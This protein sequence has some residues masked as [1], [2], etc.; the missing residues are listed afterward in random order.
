MNIM[1]YGFE[2]GPMLDVFFRLENEKIISI[3]R[4]LYDQNCSDKI[5][6][7]LSYAMPITNLWRG[8][9]ENCP[10]FPNEDISKYINKHMDWLM[11]EF[12]RDT[13]FF[14]E[15]YYEYTNIINYV[16]NRSY[17]DIIK[18]NIE[19]V[20]F[21]DI[22]HG[23]VRCMLYLLAK[24]MN[25]RT[26]F[27]FTVSAFP[28]KMFYEH[29]IEDIGKIDLL[30]DYQEEFSKYHID[31]KFEKNLDYMSDMQIKKDRGEDW[32]S[33]IRLFKHPGQWLD[34]HKNM[35]K[36]DFIKYE[37]M[38]S[39]LE[40]KITKVVIKNIRKHQYD[41]YIKT[42]A[43]AD[44][45]FNKKYVYFPLHLQPEMTT[46]A[47]GGIYRDQILAIEK[48][49]NIIPNDWFIYV[50]E[51]PKQL[52]SVRGKFFFKRLTSIPNVIYIDRS[53]NTYELIEHCQFLATITGTAAWESISGG[54]AALIFGTV[55][56]ESLPGIFKYHEGINISDI[57]NYK[58]NHL[59]LEKKMEELQKKAC[60]GLWENF[61][62]Q[63]VKDL[64]LDWNRKS[65][66]K[67]MRFLLN[68]EIKYIQEMKE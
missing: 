30:P 35:I 25:I 12:A 68:N 54:K 65:L 8:N 38:S 41:C 10:P 56:Y 5:L 15:T 32:E 6:D 52:Y 42:L 44:I 33:K 66:Y 67:S 55:W 48:I 27:L 21:S 18:N 29:A 62:I 49:R 9:W 50:K 53:V 40:Q 63:K 1:I 13:E 23:N 3:K 4:W 28:K 59:S 31:E 7:D 43:K 20:I 57:V 60:D 58:V 47:I 61:R 26:L 24:A 2:S 64:D 19:L 16:I 51:N 34:E 22:P 14:H 46:D 39:F 37:S 17:I 36:R 11:Q 45:D